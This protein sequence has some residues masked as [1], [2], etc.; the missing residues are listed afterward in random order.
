MGAGGLYMP[1]KCE[2]PR[3]DKWSSDTLDELLHLASDEKKKSLVEIVPTLYLMSKHGGMTTED[4]K[5]FESK[6]YAGGTNLKTK[7]PKW[8]TDPRLSFQHLTIEMLEWQNHALKLKIPSTDILK[9]AGYNFGWLFNAPIVDAP[10]MLKDMLEE[11]YEY[12]VDINVD[13]GQGYA[14]MNEMVADAK[15]LGCDALINCT[16]LGSMELCDDKDL[17]GGRGILLHYKRDCKR[18]F[19]DANMERDAAILTEDGPW[20]TSTDPVYIIPR[21]DVFVVGGT[22][23]EGNTNDSLTDD[24]RKRLIENAHL[25]GIDPSEAYVDEWTGFRPVRKTVRMEID[26]ETSA[27]SGVKVIHSYGHGGSGWTTYVGAAK[28]GLELLNSD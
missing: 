25:L 4:F 14:N 2:D 6:D 11:V 17:I 19:S 16:G 13:M 1:Y 24:E 28:A 27:S 10:N 18:N 12:P 22:Y 3:I 15:E 21:G 7:F 26:E 9:K 8:T 5:D 23:Y 20:G